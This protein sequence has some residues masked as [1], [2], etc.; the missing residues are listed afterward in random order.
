MATALIV[1]GNSSENNTHITGP[2]ET[3]NEATNES[4]AHSISMEF[5]FNELDIKTDLFSSIYS[6][7]K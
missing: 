5:K 1:F 3:A 7:G 2:I 4:I 6:L